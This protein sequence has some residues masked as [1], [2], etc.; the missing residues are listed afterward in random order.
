M[1]GERRLRIAKARRDLGYSPRVGLE[2]GIE[3]TVA[4]YE[5]EGLI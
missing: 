4:W 3:Q 1:C 2:E 5:R